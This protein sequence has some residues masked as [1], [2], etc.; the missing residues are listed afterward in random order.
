[1]DY[2]VSIENTQYDL[3]QIEL[4]IESF[5]IHKLQD[6]LVVAIAGPAKALTKNLSQHIRII[7]HEPHLYNSIYSVYA[8]LHENLLKEPFVL[9]HPDMLLHKPFNDVWKENIVFEPHRSD[10]KIDYPFVL[11]GA[12]RFNLVA[13]KFFQNAIALAEQL[14]KNKTEEPNNVVRAAWTNTLVNSI[15]FYDIIGQPIEM[16]LDYTGDNWEN[17]PIIH[18]KFGFPPAF[19]KRMF[20][21]LA[22]TDKNPYDVLLEQNPTNI[23]NYVHKVI[24]SYQGDI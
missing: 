19:N 20:G 6:S 22:L 3:W 15:P 11:C 18:Y 5:K 4:L 17:I 23:T 1:M 10:L 7:H 8:A 9:L 13:H 16:G 14:E 12:V 2:L 21:P 24:H